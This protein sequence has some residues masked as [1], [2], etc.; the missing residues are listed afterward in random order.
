MDF[1]LPMIQIDWSYPSIHPVT[2]QQVQN[3]ANSAW[4]LVENL[5]ELKGGIPSGNDQQF[6]VENCHRNSG[7]T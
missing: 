3:L 4:A 2:T 5:D 6:A 7:F 1:Q